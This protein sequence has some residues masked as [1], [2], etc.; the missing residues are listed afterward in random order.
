VWNV[1][2]NAKWATDPDYA[3]KILELYARTVGFAS[4]HGRAG[5]R[6]VL[7][8]ARPYRAAPRAAARA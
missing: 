3:T 5:A 4:Q 8:A 2:G 6:P 7:L 1:L